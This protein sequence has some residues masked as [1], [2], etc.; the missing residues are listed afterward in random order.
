MGTKLS[1]LIL[2]VLSIVVLSAAAIAQPPRLINFQGRVLDAAG[3]PVADGNHTFD[4][5][6]YDDSA[7]GNV[8][9][10]ELS[11]TIAT[12]DGLLTYALGTS[13]AI[14]TGM[15]ASNPELYL[16]VTVDGQVQ[17]P[18]SRLITVPYAQT[19]EEL[20][21]L[22]PLYSGP[23][24]R[25]LPSAHGLE[26][27]GFDGLRQILIHGT[28]WAQIQLHDGQS[29]GQSIN[30]MTVEINANF[31]SGGQLRLFDGSGVNT[32]DLH[33]GETGNS[34]VEFPTDAIDAVEMYNEPGIANQVR[35]ST[36][37]FLS[38]LAVNY[39][40]D[41][42]SITIPTSGYVE[43][44]S[45]CYINTHHTT[46]TSTNFYVGVAKVKTISFTDPGAVAIGHSG[47]VPTGN[48][49]VPV[50]PSRL[51]DENAGTHKYYFVVKRQTGGSVNS[52][53]T[54]AFIRAKF[55]P[56][57]YGSIVTSASDFGTLDYPVTASTSPVSFRE[58]SSIKLR[59]QTLEEINAKLEAEKE[60]LRVEN[61]RLRDEQPGPNG[62]TPNNNQN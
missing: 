53:A 30:R 21:G 47:N 43:V 37:F 9:W 27:F 38:A 25:T 52:T 57:A 18:R 45:G 16:A 22:S 20:N 39:A 4:F 42:V 58:N 12:T 32:I 24:F 8:V 59:I 61:Q 6:I 1:I 60:A 62:Q 36:H 54:K 33:G 13:S 29:D 28:N 15:F 26:T 55:F 11:V 10:S 2:A 19:S 3:A 7:G 23:A 5:R 35:S 40:V 41:S 48:H 44:S 46:G 49:L 51:F 17:T 31:T 34:S 50:Y 14:P 56:T